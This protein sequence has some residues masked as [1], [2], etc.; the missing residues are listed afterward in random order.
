MHCEA[1]EYIPA[2][3]TSQFSQLLQAC[4]GK[5]SIRSKE[6]LHDKP[7][8]GNQYAKKH[9]F[10]VVAEGWA[11]DTY[12]SFPKGYGY[13]MNVQFWNSRESHCW[14]YSS[15]KAL[16]CYERTSQEQQQTATR[17]IN[18]PSNTSAIEP[19]KEASSEFIPSVASSTEGSSKSKPLTWWA[20]LVDFLAISPIAPLTFLWNDYVQWTATNTCHAMPCYPCIDH[21][22]RFMLF[23]T[24]FGKNLC[25]G[26]VCDSRIAHWGRNLSKS[27]FCH[28]VPVVYGG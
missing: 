7:A 10:G 24:G 14:K 6:M 22:S 3:F 17:V 20:L 19:V 15:T 8:C 9:P 18:C 11:G 26:S 12:Q 21:L 27:R 1:L 16:R 28:T 25:K 23:V 13:H 4:I 5:I 2:A